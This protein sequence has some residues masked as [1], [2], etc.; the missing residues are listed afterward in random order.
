MK[1]L[2]SNLG[3]RDSLA[4]EHI[5]Q[6]KFMFFADL[7]LGRPCESR[8]VKQRPHAYD[9]Q[10][11]HLFWTFSDRAKILGRRGHLGPETSIAATLRSANVQRFALHFAKVGQ[12]P[13]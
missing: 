3:S 12:T 13:I 1:N 10:H 5:R 11:L 9:S 8:L 4:R 6:S 2:P 7:Y